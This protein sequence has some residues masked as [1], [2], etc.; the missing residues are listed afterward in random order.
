MRETNKA[1]VDSRLHEARDSAAETLLNAE[2]L[3]A[4]RRNIAG[5]PLAQ[6]GT[7][8]LSVIDGD[9]NAASLTLSNGE[10]AGY[11]VP[12]TAVML[13]NMLGEEDINP[14]GFHQWPEDVRMSSM[15][16]P[17]L[18]MTADGETVALG[19]GGSNRIRTAILQV[20]L[21]HLEFG[22][23]V[24]E[25]V[26]APRIHYEGGLLSVEPGFDEADI[27]GLSL[28]FPDI[29]R[30]DDKNLF[31]GGVHSVLYDP[32]RQDFHGAGDLRRGGVAEIL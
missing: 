31:F 30:W 5:H 10:G 24:E 6:R 27:G 3:E 16:A 26:S 21:N 20:I 14:H 25:S 18:I 4:Y 1:R 7:T 32:R 11:V 29:E 8:H 12:G 9:G 19:S 15:M 28:G 23:S 2:F 13:N 22:L 17:S